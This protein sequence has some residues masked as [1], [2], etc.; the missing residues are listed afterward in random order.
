MTLHEY[1]LCT[2]R[3]DSPKRNFC[4]EQQSWNLVCS[5]STCTFQDGSSVIWGFP[6]G[7]AVKNPSANAGDEGLI[8]VWEDPLEKQRATHS[9]IL[10]WEIP[11][12]EKPGGLQSKGSQ[13]V[14][15]HWSWVL[16]LPTVSPGF[17]VTRSYFEKHGPLC[18][19]A[20]IGLLHTLPS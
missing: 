13:R 17:S 12:T 19:Y 20:Y 14:G 18:T 11:W 10:A 3:L 9:N 15:H 16:Q 6:D 4:V 1:P 5:Q 2:W 8:L 7:S